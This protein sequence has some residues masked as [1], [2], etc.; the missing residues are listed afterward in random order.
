MKNYVQVLTQA[1]HNP[2]S[3]LYDLNCLI[4]LH[5]ASASCQLK[6]TSVA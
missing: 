5:G 6:A 2:D 1:S 4:D 3:I